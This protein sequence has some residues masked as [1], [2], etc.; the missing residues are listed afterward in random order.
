MSHKKFA[1]LENNKPCCYRTHQVDRSWNRFQFKSWAAAELYA[2]N[3][4]GQYAPRPG[5]LQPN[6]PYW[7]A[8]TED[9][10]TIIVK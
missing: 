3:W 4:L 2:L 9:F 1:V 6:I 7:Y 8:G 10:I 5:T